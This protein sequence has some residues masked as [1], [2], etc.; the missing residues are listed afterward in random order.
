MMKE[1][2]VIMPLTCLQHF[3]FYMS[4]QMLLSNFI[5]EEVEAQKYTIINYKQAK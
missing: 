3:S 4:E 2:T 5:D 1:V